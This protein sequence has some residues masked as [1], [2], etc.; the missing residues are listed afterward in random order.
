[1]NMNMN[2]K[3][4]SSSNAR[5]GGF[6]LIE[7]LVV[8]AIIAIL[9]ALLLPALSRAKLKGQSIA[10][11]SNLR[12]LTI[13]W[14]MYADD[15][16]GML[17]PNWI[18]DSRAWIDGATG[19]VRNPPG[20]TNPVPIKTG[21]LFPYNPSLGVYQCPAAVKGPS[22]APNPRTVRNYS[23]QGRMGGANDSDSVKY[24]VISTE[25][26]LGSAYPQYNRM[27][28]IQLPD[29]SEAMAFVDESI[30]TID[31]GYFSVDTSA[32]AWMNSPTVRH[33][34][35]GVLAFADGHSER[36]RWRVLNVEQRL[37]VPAVSPNTTVDLLRLQRAVFRPR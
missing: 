21:L 1:M 17:V 31:D 5:R 3:T 34:Q 12:Q 8:I 28:Q 27:A 25:F 15:Y 23:L 32:G 16:R 22:S 4:R 20:T 13:A 2:L 11:V 37:D 33:G 19:W 9:A 10:C 6:T 29:P 35:S 24:G 30:E 26:V 14:S 18:F 7:L 36:W